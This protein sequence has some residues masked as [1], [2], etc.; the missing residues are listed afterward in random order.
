MTMPNM[1]GVQLVGEV[2]RIRPD[3]PVILCTGFSHQINEEN[4][5]QLGINAFVMKPLVRD[6][7]ASLIRRILDG[8]GSLFH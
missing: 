5:G 2:H 8:P 4:A 1:T 7:L 6:Q 3:L